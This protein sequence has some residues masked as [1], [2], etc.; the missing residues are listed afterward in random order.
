MP[1][2][3]AIDVIGIQSYV[4]ASNRLRDVV[5]A[6]HLVEW[7]TSREASRLNQNNVASPRVVV[8][9]G[10]NAILQF[11]QF[12]SIKDAMPF[13]SHYTRRL[14]ET[15]PG[16][17]VAIAHGK[18]ERGKLAQGL[19]ALQ[20]QIAKAKLERRPHAPQLGLS[21]MQ[22]CAVSGLPAAEF[23]P[24]DEKWVSSRIS[25]LRDSNTLN[26]A[27]LR[28]DEFLSSSNQLLRFPVELDR[29]GRSY[30]DTSL[31]GVV[32]VDGNG[33][34]LRIQKWLLGKLQES[35]QT[36]DDQLILDF[37]KWSEALEK[38]GKEV[39]KSV[40]QRVVDRVVP[41][42]GKFMVKGQPSPPRELD[43]E[44]RTEPDGTVCLPMR[45]ILLGG[46]DLT[47][48]CD[49]RIALDLAAAALRAF[50]EKSESNADLKLLGSE[51]FTACAGVALVKAHTPFS[52]GYRLSEELCRSAKSAKRKSEDIHEKIET[53]CWLDWHIG[54]IRPDESVIDIRGRQYKG[55]N[56][57]VLTCRPY[58]IDA[59]DSK[60]LTWEWLDS[61]LLGE[62]EG[63]EEKTRLSFRNPEV[64]GERR[65]KVKALAGLVVEGGDA[66]KK[67]FEAWSSAFPNLKLPTLI[68]NNGFHADRTP[69]LDA[70]ELLD[71]HLRLE[72]PRSLADSL[73]KTT[74]VKK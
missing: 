61:V 37:Q 67:Q 64:W 43:F 21:V 42:N 69:L 63:V 25:K 52:R 39:L 53:G 1:V 20:I 27:N 19:L 7:A 65:N 55:E 11:E 2:L 12:E 48:V 24:R 57:E 41:D 6:S 70:V 44:L 45:P 40:I 71:I 54:A 68:E 15:A 31:L 72:P 66:V 18:Y 14:L 35:P 26:S 5:G 3:T 28:W 58:P 17:D 10:G 50:K 13:V 62:H 60:T 16:L 46:D 49:G 38:L 9:G 73:P 56:G 32:H 47:F 74:E 4:F 59:S 8:A 29:M 33:I 36:T 30:G 51:P 34:G 23:S 22:P